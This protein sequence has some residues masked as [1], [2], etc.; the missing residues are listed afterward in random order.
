MTSKTSPLRVG[1]GGPVGTGKTA[2]L[3]RLCK[4]L[5][6]DY[7]TAAITNSTTIKVGKAMQNNPFSKIN[8]WGNSAVLAYLWKG[9][10]HE[11]LICSGDPQFSMDLCA[12]NIVLEILYAKKPSE[13]LFQVRPPSLVFQIPPPVAPK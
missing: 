11:I 1:I 7:N 4:M 8:I 10:S 5:R 6:D 13:I 3:D 9:F 2:L 12:A